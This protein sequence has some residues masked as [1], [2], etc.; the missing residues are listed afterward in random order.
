MLL[1]QICKY[2]IEKANFAYRKI[3]N[4][5]RSQL[6]S[7]LLNRIKEM[8]I[9][10]RTELSKR[11]Y[12]TSGAVGVNHI[13]LWRWIGS[14]HPVLCHPDN[15]R[16]IKNSL[17]LSQEEEIVEEVKINETYLHQ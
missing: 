13:T 6:R 16:V 11:L 17:G 15:I 2:V 3:D 1:M 5:L 10:D 12:D 9:V 8:S 4:M 7:D 14:N